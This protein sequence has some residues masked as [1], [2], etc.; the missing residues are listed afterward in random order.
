MLV[1]QENKKVL[2]DERNTTTSK[3]TK[4]ELIVTQP[5]GERWLSRTVF[6]MPTVFHDWKLIYEIA[7]KR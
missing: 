4:I 2:M 5:N 6:E 3:E 7:A 1:N